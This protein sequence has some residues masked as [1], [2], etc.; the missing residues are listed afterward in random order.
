VR[1]RIS[2][3]EVVSFDEGGQGQRCPDGCEKDSRLTI[4]IWDC[5]RNE[6]EGEDEV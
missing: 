3:A 1:G 2:G 5:L 4:V 6:E